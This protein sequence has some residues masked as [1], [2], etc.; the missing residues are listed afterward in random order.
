MAFPAPPKAP[1]TLPEGDTATVQVKVEEG[2]E[3]KRFILVVPG[4][5]IVW[6]AGVAVAF[7]TGLTVTTTGKGSPEQSLATGV[8]V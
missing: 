2:I 4:E 3:L 8:T 7:G 5:Q 6:A 1:V